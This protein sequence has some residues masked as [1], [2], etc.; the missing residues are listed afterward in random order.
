MDILS[1]YLLPAPSTYRITL[2]ALAKTF[3]GIVRRSASPLSD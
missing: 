3:G 1:T 2:S